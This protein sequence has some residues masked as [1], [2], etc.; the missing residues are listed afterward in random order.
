MASGDTIHLLNWHDALF[1]SSGGAFHQRRNGHM[2]IGFNAS[3][4]DSVDF[5]LV[6]PQH[7]AGTTG[8]TVYIYYA[9]SGATT[10]D[11]V[12]DVSFER[13]ADD[14]FDL[15]ADGFAAVNSVTDTV[16]NV[17]GELSVPSVAF[18]DGADMDSVVAGDSF[19]FRITRDADNVA[20]TCGGGTQIARVQ[21]R[22]T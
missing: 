11:V 5:E 16:A 3:A 13:H 7:Y 9:A 4:D 18:T 6:M 12:W 10:G 19:R 20:D 21:I 22:E 17:D 14:A 2:L 15:D 8:V 1:L